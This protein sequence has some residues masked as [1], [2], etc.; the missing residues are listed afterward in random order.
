MSSRF[1]PNPQFEEGIRSQPEYRQALEEAAGA[2]QD[3]AAAFARTAHAPWMKRQSKAIIVETDA[4][5]VSVVNTDY[6]G[7]LM[8]WGGRNNSAHAPLRRAVRA[9]GLHFDIASK[10]A[11]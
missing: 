10:G 5:D 1:V 4:D 8:E 7:H 9:A 11:A 3:H 6:A 2:V